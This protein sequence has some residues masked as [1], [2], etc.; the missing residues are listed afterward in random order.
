MRYLIYLFTAL[1]TFILSV[2]AVRTVRQVYVTGEK[3]LRTA[4]TTQIRTVRQVYVVGEKPLP[5]AATTHVCGGFGV[6]TNM[7]GDELGL[8]AND[9]D[10]LQKVSEEINQA[11]DIVAHFE[12]LEGTPLMIREVRM[13]PITRQQYHRITGWAEDTSFDLAYLHTVTLVNNTDR[14]INCFALVF[15]SKPVKRAD[16]L[17]A[18]IEPSVPIG[19]PVSPSAALLMAPIEPNSSIIYRREWKGPLLSIEE[20]GKELLVKVQGVQFEDGSHWGRFAEDISP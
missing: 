18:W 19:W 4:L 17:R 3:P 7:V 11:Q 8:Y 20:D 2:A 6:F 13:K 10:E 14:R 12:N 5:V 1:L 15:T 9:E 16:G